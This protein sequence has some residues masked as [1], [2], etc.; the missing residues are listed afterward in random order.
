MTTTPQPHPQPPP[1]PPPSPA[2]APSPSSPRASARPPTAAGPLIASEAVLKRLFREP[3][4]ARAWRE[5]LYSLLSL[6][7]ALLGLVLVLVTVLF[8]V[9]SA[10]LLLMPLLA[11]TLAADRAFGQLQRSLARALLGI[12]IPT[13]A[14]IPRHPGLSGLLGQHL[15]DP[16]AWRTVG[17]LALRVPLGLLEFLFGF[18]WWAYGVIFMLYP[19]LWKLE[20][21]HEVDAHGVPH[22]FGIALNGFYFDTWPRAL[23]VVLAGALLILASP[24]VRRAPLA[25]DRRLMVWLLGPTRTSLRLVHLT[26]TREHV[27]N[28][29]AATLRQ[30]ERDLHDGAQARLVALGMRLSRAE[31]GL[32]KG[33]VD[34]AQEL[35]RESREETKEI[36]QEL[37]E[38]V[39]GIHPPVLDAGLLAALTTLAARSMIPSTVQVELARRP[40]AAAETMLYFAAA[41]LLTNAAKHSGARQTAITVHD[42]D[43]AVLLT[44]TDNGAG[45]AR[46]DSGGSGL[47]GLSERIR[48]TDGTLTIA[49]PPGGPTTVTVSLPDRS[50]PTPPSPPPTHPDPAQAQAQ[51]QGRPQS[52]SKSHR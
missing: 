44:V 14:R 23:L 26:E 46:L 45:G 21:V 11:L 16:A 37:R 31:R 7:L 24:W 2:P 52:N 18:V 47:R 40:T 20:P 19:L 36:I 38:L 43:G 12:D 30:I 17:Y 29:A 34:K 28:E 9:G 4:A 32:A 35:L 6:P 5:L 27:I 41:E 13:P 49:S 1:A 25:A 22:S 8:G 10:G 3:F 51:T 42:I 33:D 48:A 15:G 50:P 39:R